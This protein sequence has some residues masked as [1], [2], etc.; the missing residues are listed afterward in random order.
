[1]TYRL[2][3]SGAA[4]AL[5]GPTP[6][7]RRDEARMIREAAALLDHARSVAA[8]AEAARAEGFAA[9]RQEGLRLVLEERDR[10][11]ADL[12]VPV[13]R[14]V[15]QAQAA[16]HDDIATLALEAIRRMIGALPDGDLLAGLARQAVAALP[17]DEVDRIAVPPASHLAVG[18]RLGAPWAQLIVADAQLAPGDCVIHT[19]SGK[20]VASV[21]LQLE[22]LAERWGAAG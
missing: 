7:I 20:V 2:Y 18:E 22:R 19:R 8:E 3:H 15:E 14:Q 6:L 4:S 11:L 5:F 12:I 13:A 10:T 21:S 16:L 9:G 1:M 17:L